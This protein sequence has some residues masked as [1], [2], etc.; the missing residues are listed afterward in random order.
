[1]KPS[2]IIGSLTLYEATR[3]RVSI[4]SRALSRIVKL[5]R[6]LVKLVREHGL[7]GAT[8]LRGI[9]ASAHIHASTPPGSCASR[10]TCVVIEIVDQPERVHQILPVLDE[11]IG[12]GLITRE[13]VQV[14][15][16]R[17]PANN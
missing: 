16:Y 1:M 5:V 15:A 4:Q 9:E 14:I 12:E 6:E 7:A 17:G 13:R 3:R 8:V 2:L 11:M 10:K